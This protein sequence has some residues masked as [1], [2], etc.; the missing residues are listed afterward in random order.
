MIAQNLRDGR[1][2]AIGTVQTGPAQ[3]V[4]QAA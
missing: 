2:S 1:S 3:V 4:V